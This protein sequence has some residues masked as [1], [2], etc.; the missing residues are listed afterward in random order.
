MLHCPLTKE[1]R[2]LI[3]RNELMRMKPTAFLINTA[4][5]PVVQTE[6]LIEALNG[7]IIAGA[8]SDVFDS[9]PPFDPDLPILN[10]PNLFVTPHIGFA[11]E[12]AMDLRAQIVFDSVKAWLDGGQNSV[13]VPRID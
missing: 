7:E 9:E 6:A 2:G 12:E 11:T 5:G 10:V 4:R 1:T 13:V 3:G 8:A